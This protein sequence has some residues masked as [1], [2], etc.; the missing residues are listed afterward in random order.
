MDLRMVK[1]SAPEL[2]ASQGDLHILAVP[3][4]ESSV[5]WSDKELTVFTSIDSDLG[6]VNENEY[7]AL[8]QIFD[9]WNQCYTFYSYT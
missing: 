8:L 6:S 7:F 2:S 4:E 5:N 3:D 1:V 9:L